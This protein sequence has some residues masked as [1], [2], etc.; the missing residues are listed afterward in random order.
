MKP[1]VVV[2]SIVSASL[3]VTVLAV[4]NGH[5]SRTQ[6]VKSENMRLTAQWEENSAKFAEA[7]QLVEVLQTNLAARNQELSA[8]SN[9]LAKTEA[10][11]KQLQD[12]NAT[13]MAQ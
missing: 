8:A 13:T 7:Q 6:A 12:D 3:L 1:I 4:H 5:R 11:V 9:E 10:A 2:L